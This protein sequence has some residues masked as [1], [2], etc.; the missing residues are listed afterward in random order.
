MEHSYLSRP[1]LIPHFGLLGH[2]KTR[3]C[4]RKMASHTA[5]S[6]TP[7]LV[8]RWFDFTIS[9]LRMFGL[10][11][12]GFSH[13]N[14]N[15][16]PLNQSDLG[17]L[18]IFSEGACIFNWKKGQ[19]QSIVALRS[20]M[21][22]WVIACVAATN[23]ECVLDAPFDLRDTSPLSLINSSHCFCHWARQLP[24]DTTITYYKTHLQKI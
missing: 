13:T 15:N 18:G 10:H 24:I 3:L 1:L 12:L 14:N 11:A 21:H 23:V 9:W 7:W 4:Y 17:W 20:G 19:E 2:K 5:R 8:R 6:E 16:N 22:W